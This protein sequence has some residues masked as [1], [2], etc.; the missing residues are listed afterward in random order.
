MLLFFGTLYTSCT[1]FPNT[2]ELILIVQC[3]LQCSL[4]DHEQMFEMLARSGEIKYI[5]PMQVKFL[6]EIPGYCF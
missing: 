1:S 5:C 4:G 2:Q 3:W 6:L